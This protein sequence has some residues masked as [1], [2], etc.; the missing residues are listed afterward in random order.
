LVSTE[1][2]LAF[3]G[4]LSVQ[5]GRKPVVDL[6]SHKAR[7]LLCY[8]A[9]SDQPQTRPML[10][11]LLWGDM[12]ES[13]A[14]MNLRKALSQLRQQ[15][16][17]HLKITRQ[18]V[19][20]NRAAPH[21]IDVLT[22]QEAAG[23]IKKIDRINSVLLIRL[24][25]AIALY[26]GDFLE[27]FYI[28]DAPEFEAWY[29]GK[30]AYFR[31][32][33]LQLMHVV[34]SEHANQGRYTSAIEFTRQLLRLEP[35]SEGAHRQMM[36]LLALSGGRAL[37]LKQYETLCQV[38]DRELGVEPEPESQKLYEDIRD[39]RL[40]GEPSQQAA[41]SGLES[42]PRHNLPS[43]LTPLIGRESDLERV[44]ALL[45]DPGC[46]LLSV[47]GPGGIGKSSLSLRVAAKQVGSYRHGVYLVP[48]AGVASPRELPS[49]IAAALGLELLGQSDPEQQLIHILDNQH[50]LLLLDNFEHLLPETSLLTDILRQ[51]PRVSLLVTSRQ[52]L[53]LRAEWVFPLAGL[54][55]PDADT[56]P[57]AHSYA[58]VQMFLQTAR[59]IQ[60]KFTLLESDWP[61][62]AR[63][64]RLVE[65]TP[66][67]IDL[68][69]SWTRLLSP[70]EIAAEIERGMDILATAPRDL[71]DRHRSMRA[72]FDHSWNLLS[73]S[74]RRVLRRLSVFR[75]GFTRQ[76]AE[77]V[78]GG[79]LPLLSA[80]IDKSLLRLEPRSGDMQ[81]Y[82]LHE[83]VRQVAYARLLDAGEACQT[84]GRH[85]DYYLALAEQAEA[86][87]VGPNSPMWLDRL[88]R[89]HD[90]LRAA[91]SSATASDRAG[92]G[93][94]A[95]RLLR[96]LVWFW[97]TRGP[98][99]EGLKWAE[100][101]LSLDSSHAFSHAGAVWVAGYLNHLVGNHTVARQ[102]LEN[103]VGLCRQLGPSGKQE[104]AWALNFL[105][106][107]EESAGDL[108]SAQ[109]CWQESLAIWRELDDPRGIAP[110][111]VN[112]GFCTPWQQGDYDQA[113][114]YFEDGLAAARAS[115][116]RG[117]L[118]CAYNALGESYTY[119]D[120][121]ARAH[122]LY[123]K[124]L[125]VCRELHSNWWAA[126]VLALQANLEARQDHPGRLARAARM[127]GAAET[128]YK[129]AGSSPRQLEYGS[130]RRP[131]A[132]ARRRLGDD[133]F[134]EAS[135]QGQSM[136][137]D[138]A[139]AFGL[140]EPGG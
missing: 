100:L 36:Q 114:R 38:L 27:G 82:D 91:F 69:A 77:E 81:R 132:A 131:I 108:V 89:D 127:W 119:Q 109:S 75:G 128:L 103:G 95:Q 122:T 78:A 96:A 129:H 23:Q 51:A 11:G 112:L 67:A 126:E 24:E 21:A 46:R 19:T 30:R 120:D 40:Q 138:Q 5:R 71:P 93:E 136:T 60:A 72:V 58:A 18:S 7:A 134:T 90:N 106:M 92:D 22:L 47:V 57:E 125:L 37:A 10:A 68:A 48:L 87:L 26:Q 42:G 65:G 73:A 97:L 8:L 117:W 83:L 9:L 139:L 94:L 66:L 135:S 56:D 64:C 115:G 1:L 61:H 45:E 98:F 13:N 88:A 123:R 79:S 14:L 99:D 28:R 2:R 35:W 39:G 74:E 59:R 116:D 105:G 133:G 84:N 55:F 4:G 33:A 31:E 118:L 102:K 86:Q 6:K 3:L 41:S 52:R 124:A 32:L 15:V 17:D 85:L 29:L 63:I 70:A 16:G 113:R 130:G 62:L 43:L 53:N 34:A 50:L 20:F 140:E 12:P 80:L 111:L 107:E 44:G 101:A 137:L 121:F 76:A 49:A 25:Q 110:V 104:L 54:P